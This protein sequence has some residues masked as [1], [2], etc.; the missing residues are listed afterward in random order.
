MA[1]LLP[2]AA[3]AQSFDWSGFYAGGTAAVG[4]T[5][6]SVDYTLPSGGTPGADRYVFGG[7]ALVGPGISSA[8]LPA[9]ADLGQLSLLGGITAGFNAQ[10]GTMVFGVEADA[11]GFL[12]PAATSDF[13]RVVVDLNPDPDVIVTTR[14]ESEV[15]L[16]ALMTL[17]GR[18]GTA[19]DH[20]LLYATGG[21][22]LGFGTMS[23][24]LTLVDDTG[25]GASISGKASGGPLYGFALG[26]GAE[27]AAQQN[28]TFKVEGLYYQLAG[29]GTT[30]TGTG[31]GASAGDAVETIE[32]FYNPSGFIVRSGVNVHF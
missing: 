17:R 1:G 2:G 32:A 21:L 30:T 29:F 12:L 6:D 5:G 27:F 22:A 20:V 13:T 8:V 15:T 3:L 10:A 16:H 28:M 31:L 7:G 23:S 25:D 14:L 26:V 19:I 4:V 24:A 11:S 18:V 9:N